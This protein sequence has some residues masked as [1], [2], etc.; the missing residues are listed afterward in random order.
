MKESLKSNIKI[1]FK[2]LKDISVIFEIIVIF[3]VSFSIG[4]ILNNQDPLF[5]KTS[6]FNY[7]YIPILVLSLFYGMG[8]GLLLLFLLT[9]SSFIYLKEFPEFFF[10]NGLMLSLISGEFYFYW[11]KKIESIESKATYLEEK[12]REIGIAAH[13]IRISHDI[14]EKSYISKPY[15]IRA[16]LHKI[17][18]EENI[19][20]FFKFISNQF[21]V[22]SF[23]YVEYDSEKEEIKNVYPFNSDKKKIDLEHPLIQKMLF[24]Q[25][26]VYIK[27]MID[28]KNIDYIATIPIFDINEKLKAFFLIEHIPF[29][30]YNIENLLSIQLVS[31]YFLFNIAKQ[32]EIEAI[33]KENILPEYIPSDFKYEIFKLRKLKKISDVDSSIVIIEVKSSYSS[34]IDNFL[35][36]SLRALDFY[37]KIENKENNIFI[38]V[39]PLIAKEGGIGFI[40][41]LY[42]QFDFLDHKYKYFVFNIK[43]LNKVNEILNNLVKG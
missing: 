28:I 40:N 38:I 14:L 36:Q 43:D 12:L 4:Y 10:L 33:S 1:N 7:F 17:Q 5:I 34:I 3:V 37:T 26:I 19:E 23:V 25:E 41:R 13:T 30:H 9:I 42:E 27:D 11:R 21:F 2:S 22:E 24:L 31:Q 6:N 15:T 35:G 20:N 32:K 39:L 16:V 18:K 8:A 29:I